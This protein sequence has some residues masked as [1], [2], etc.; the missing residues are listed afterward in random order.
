[1]LL[2]KT[3]TLPPNPLKTSSL[4]IL[5]YDLPVLIVN[6]WSDITLELLNNTISNYKNKYVTKQFNYN[7]LLLKYWI[8]KITTS[9]S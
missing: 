2:S 9:H 6:E 5:F 8:N 1:M 4:D 3:K 7:K